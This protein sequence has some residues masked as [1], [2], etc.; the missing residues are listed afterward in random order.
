MSLLQSPILDPTFESDVEMTD[1]RDAMAALAATACLVTAAD[2]GL[3]LGR[4]VT[5]A[6]S[7]SAQPPAILVSI[8]A[9]APLAAL[10]R[11]RAGFSFAIFAEGQQAIADGFAGKVP[12][13]HRFEQGT[14]GDWPSGH[15]RLAHAVAAMDCS[16]IG[17]IELDSHI[18]FAGGLTRIGLDRTARPLV[19]HQRQ[20]KSV[21]PL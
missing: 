20:Y 11:K 13:E 1:F 9:S 2:G 4:T 8:D 7:L 18:L 16:V 19:W 5:A 14:W 17:E 6:F 3:R 10:I 12:Q 21:Q 15:P